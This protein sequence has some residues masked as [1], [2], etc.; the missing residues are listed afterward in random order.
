MKRLHVVLFSASL[1]AV[2][3]APSAPS[4]PATATPATQPA[5]PG[6]TTKDPTSSVKETPAPPGNRPQGSDALHDW[7]NGMDL[8]NR[9]ESNDT[10]QLTFI[11]ALDEP[12]HFRVTGK[13]RAFEAVGAAVLK[14]PNGQL[15]PQDAAGNH[16][17]RIQAS[18]GAPAWGDF[19]ADF[20]Y[21]AVYRGQTVIMEFY[22]NSPKDGSKQHVLD[23]SLVLP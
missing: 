14:D 6:P 1:L 20:Q 16:V 12:R 8:T 17:V 5:S 21:P 22:V 13:L 18:M 10:Y 11:K 15:V 7:E 9:H 19:T 23:V 3:C 4:R 2:G